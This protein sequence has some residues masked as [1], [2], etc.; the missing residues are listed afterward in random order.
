MKEIPFGLSPLE[1]AVIVG[2]AGAII[3]HLL[4]V[5]WWRAVCFVPGRTLRRQL[6]AAAR[7]SKSSLQAEIINRLECSF[8]S[9]P[10]QSAQ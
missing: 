10:A 7:A 9:D 5:A 3:S 1:F 8:E 2:L 4:D 6:K